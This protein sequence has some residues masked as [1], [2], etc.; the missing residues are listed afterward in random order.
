[1]SSTVGAKHMTC[2]HI[3]HHVI[4]LW[5]SNVFFHAYLC[6]KQNKNSDAKQ[7][8]KSYLK[9]LPRAPDRGIIEQAI[10]EL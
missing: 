9:Y 2:L 5:T 4:T 6:E 3:F 7:D 1:M 10:R 8:L